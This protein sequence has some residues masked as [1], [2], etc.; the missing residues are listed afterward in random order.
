MSPE[1]LL[2]AN[3][4]AVLTAGAPAP[5]AAPRA[6]LVGEPPI[7]ALLADRSGPIQPDQD[8]LH[9]ALAN[10]TRAA[11]D[12]GIA[13]LILSA[14]AVSRPAPAAPAERSDLRWR[15]VPLH[16]PATATA[17]L[18][19]QTAQTFGSADRLALV[20]RHEI[21]GSATLSNALRVRHASGP[22]DTQVAVVGQLSLAQ[23]G[24]M[25]LSYRSSTTLALLPNLSVG[26]DAHGPLGTL[27]AIRPGL[28]DSVVEPNVKFTLPVLGA[29]AGATT[30][31]RVPTG[32]GAGHDPDKRTEFH[33]NLTIRKKL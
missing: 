26:A 8:G 23:G 25:A 11:I 9:R 21:D 3:L 4:I 33:W 31:W 30:G 10:D 13:E 16:P 29:T 18:A 6:G 32:A 22:I 1:T 7:S 15:L 17:G 14:L 19:G 2:A 20:W 24:P 28:A 5:D 27:A 12:A